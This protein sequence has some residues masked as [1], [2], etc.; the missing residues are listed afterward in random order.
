MRDCSPHCGT[1]VLARRFSFAGLKFLE[2]YR[3]LSQKQRARTPVCTLNSA[4]GERRTANGERRTA[5]GERRTANGER[6][7]A[8][9]E[10]RTANGERRTANG[11]RRTANGE[12][13]TANEF[14]FEFDD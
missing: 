13:R 12:R 4:N 6:R 5:N 10:R 11:E 1:G 7:T 2:V 14:E 9:G 8:N 3:G